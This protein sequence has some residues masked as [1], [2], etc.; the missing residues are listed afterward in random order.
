MQRKI[1]SILKVIMIVNRRAPNANYLGHLNLIAPDNFAAIQPPK[2]YLD[3][4][5]Y[6]NEII[7]IDPFANQL[8]QSLKNPE[9]KG[10]EFKLITNIDYT[11][12]LSTLNVT[13][14]PK[15]DESKCVK[16]GT[17]VKVC[18]YDVI[19]FGSTGFP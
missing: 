8:G 16:C 17:C 9:L 7:K 1:V 11:Q 19:K 15:L 13:G 2:P 5:D 12:Q 18:P 3:A 14:P 10:V 4:W 6:D